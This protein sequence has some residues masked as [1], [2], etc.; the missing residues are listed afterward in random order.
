MVSSLIA[1]H[2]YQ[3]IQRVHRSAFEV[4][5]RDPDHPTVQLEVIIDGSE[6]FR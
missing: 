1:H 5:T 4:D 3:L 2:D 6:K